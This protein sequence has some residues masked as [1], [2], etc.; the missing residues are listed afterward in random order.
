VLLFTL[1]CHINAP[2]S[3]GD[4][5]SSTA[6]H[7]V[8]VMLLCRPDMIAIAVVSVAHVSMGV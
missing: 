2:P 5:G 1:S 8:F 3:I 6:S 7:A 4:G